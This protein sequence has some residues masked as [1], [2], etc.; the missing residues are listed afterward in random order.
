MRLQIIITILFQIL[1][2]VKI[3][4]KCGF[5]K[6]WERD[7]SSKTSRSFYLYCMSH[8]FTSF[9]YCGTRSQEL[10]IC[11]KR[12]SAGPKTVSQ[13]QDTHKQELEERYVSYR[14][15]TPGL[16]NTC[17][18]MS[19]TAGAGTRCMSLLSPSPNLFYLYFPIPTWGNKK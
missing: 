14:L 8:V 19:L 12:R 16:D 17:L 18:F 13:R 1:P 5:D 6:K 3:K 15:L 11:W 4:E 2:R 7:K 9:L 10:I